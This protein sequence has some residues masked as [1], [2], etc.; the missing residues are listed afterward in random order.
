MPRLTKQEKREIFRHLEADK[1]L[2]DKYRFRLFKDTREVELVWNGKTDA[3]CDSVLP[4]KTEELTYPHLDMSARE[5]AALCSPAAVSRCLKD[6]TNKLIRGDNRLVLS[7]LKNGPLREAIEAH[8]GVKLI[9]IDPPF[10]AGADFSIAITIGEACLTEKKRILEEIAYRDTWGR[11]ADSFINMIYERLILMRD[12]LAEDG[13]IYAHCDWR[14][15][16]MLRIIL[17]EVF[18]HYHNE[19]IWHYTGG[20]R[21]ARHFSKK[22]DSIFWYSKGS[23]WIF[24]AD[25]IRVPYKKTSGYAKGGITSASGKHYL[26][27]PLGTIPDDVWDI[28]II[29]PLASERLGYPTQKPEA[30]L[31]RIIKASSSEGDLV[32]DFFC[33]SG[34]TA[35]VAEKLGRKWIAVDIGK[36]AIHVTRKRLI[37][38]QRDLKNAGKDYRAFAILSFGGY[39]GRHYA[40]APERRGKENSRQPAGKESGFPDM[41]V[42]AYQAERVEGSPPFHGKKVG[43]MVVV[44]P[45]GMPVTRRFVDEMILE[46]R[47]RRV[48]KV[49]L[50]GFEFSAGLFPDMLYNAHAEGI[51]IVPRHIPA[52]V[53]DKRT[54]GKQ[55]L[56]FHEAAFIKAKIL[57]DIQK[58]QRVAVQL[59]D[60]SVFHSCDSIL[61][62]GLKNKGGG[63]AAEQSRILGNSHNKD[64]VAA[65]ESLFK[66]WTDRV[67]YWSVD[68][69]FGSRQGISHTPPREGGEITELWA[70]EY[71]FDNT[72]CSFRTKH[73]RR[74]ELQ[75]AF[76]DYPEAGRKK[77]A[78]KVVDVFGNGAIVVLDVNLT[79]ENASC[80]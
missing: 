35:A 25:G 43:R 15:N 64:S 46:C 67:D 22:H 65:G 11:G 1:A 63:I 6:W 4:L 12:L 71:I 69:D 57:Y 66:K 20:G 17:E 18:K 27:D 29:N 45:A 36:L 49:D 40:D 73:D 54:E 16:S 72:W 10:D 75:S 5:E 19:I 59:T 74:L 24:N 55:Q 7:S 2:P 77:I 51:H 80:G 48:T 28:P 32:A 26:P 61:E 14:V 39:E 70:N 44:G 68:F 37:N 41:I 60:F 9:Y 42:R 58:T 78:V 47:K 52:D 50:L 53:F 23:S 33:G 13:S 38:V 3:V 56:V 30:L 34:T 31:E 76:Y 62:A 8:G 21:A 79:D